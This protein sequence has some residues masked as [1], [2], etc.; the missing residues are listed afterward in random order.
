MRRSRDG[1]SAVAPTDIS[2]FQLQPTAEAE[3]AGSNGGVRGR[4]S[5]VRYL[6][7]RCFEIASLGSPAQTTPCRSPPIFS[8]SSQGGVHASGLRRGV[9]AAYSVCPCAL[10]QQHTG[11]GGG[12]KAG[13]PPPPHPPVLTESPTMR[14]SLPLTHVL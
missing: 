14:L 1:A 2:L 9:A 3:A 13:A 4:E 11:C 10:P 8:P 6:K 5:E 7:G 12:L